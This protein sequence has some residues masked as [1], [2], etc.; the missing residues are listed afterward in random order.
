MFLPTARV[1]I[2]ATAGLST[3]IGV[4]LG[5]VCLLGAVFAGLTLSSELLPALFRWLSLAGAL[6][7]IWLAADALRFRDPPSRNP[8]LSRARRPVLDG[9]AI[10]FANPAALL[11]YAV[12]PGRP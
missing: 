6:Y 10:A 1:T 4:A 3:V 11:F 2:A 7:L 9:L 12:P 8:N 5:D